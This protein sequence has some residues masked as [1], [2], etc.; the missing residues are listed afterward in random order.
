[1]WCLKCPP[2]IDKWGKT[3]RNAC[4]E[5]KTLCVRN[6]RG[7]AAPSKRFVRVGTKE[8]KNDDFQLNI[9]FE[10]WWLHFFGL[11]CS[12][13][14][15]KTNFHVAIQGNFEKWEVSGWSWI[16]GLLASPLCVGFRSTSVQKWS[17]WAGCWMPALVA[18]C[19]KTKLGIIYSNPNLIV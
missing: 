3:W 11:K 2:T 18:I 13:A 19:F 4:F 15:W 6:L 17:S 16:Q 8:V 7:S 1:M 9:G 12:L 10:F 14:Q 5:R